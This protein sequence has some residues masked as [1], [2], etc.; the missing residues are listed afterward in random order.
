LHRAVTVAEE[1]AGAVDVAQNCATYTRPSPKTASAVALVSR[2]TPANA[3]GS[4]TTDMPLPPP[5][6]T[7]LITTG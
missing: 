1:D 4:S 5:P 6:A 2:K 7:A 3:F